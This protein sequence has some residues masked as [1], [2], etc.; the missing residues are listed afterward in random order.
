MKMSREE[1]SLIDMKHV[2]FSIAVNLQGLVCFFV[3]VEELVI[4]GF[5]RVMRSLIFSPPR[6]FFCI[7]YSGQKMID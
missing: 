5:A 7:L 3:V 4:W 2:V 1:S 6:G